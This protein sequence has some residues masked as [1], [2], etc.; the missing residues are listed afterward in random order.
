MFACAAVDVHSLL[1][2]FFPEAVRCSLQTGDDNNFCC[3]AL[4]NQQCCL[5][6][7]CFCSTLPPCPAFAPAPDRCLLANDQFPPGIDH[8][9]CMTE[10]TLDGEA[11]F[12]T[13]DGIS[14]AFLLI[15]NFTVAFWAQAR[16]P[17]NFDQSPSAA[18]VIAM[19][20]GCVFKPQTPPIAGGVGFFLSTDGF[21]IQ[22][23]GAGVLSSIFVQ[24]QQLDGWHHYAIVFDARVPSV[25]IDG[26]L[27]PGESALNLTTAMTFRLAFARTLVDT[28]RGPLG[29]EGWISEVRL[30]NRTMP[31]NEALMQMSNA[32]AWEF[33][34]A[35]N[36]C[37]G[38]N[39]TGTDIERYQLQQ[40]WLVCEV[41]LPTC[42]AVNSSFAVGDIAG[43]LCEFANRTRS[44]VSGVWSDNDTVVA[45]PLARWLLNDSSVTVV[46]SSGNGY[47][48]QFV[49]VVGVDYRFSAPVLFNGAYFV[50]LVN[51][52]VIDFGGAT[53]FNF[54]L[55]NSL[56]HFGCA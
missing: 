24:R 46:D 23:H 48:G 43:C 31:G 40:A 8:A 36:G 52:S 29:F 17:L 9:L 11:E 53:A 35:L 42:G 10:A 26:T 14:T 3:P 19:P 56:F 44:C 54:G 12:A 47:D 27:V 1:F 2:S 28:N 37:S 45:R 32:S 30:A 33:S 41:L 34:Y 15:D 6:S 18:G 5:P 50:S 38:E 21:T 13:G 51:S 22:Q 25:Y 16:E 39:H 7:A 20:R 49:G 55:R 4:M